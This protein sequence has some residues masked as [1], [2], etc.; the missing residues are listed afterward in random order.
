MVLVIQFTDIGNS[1]W[2]SAVGK[3]ARFSISDIQI[4]DVSK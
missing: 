3:S 2:S 1:K 4:T